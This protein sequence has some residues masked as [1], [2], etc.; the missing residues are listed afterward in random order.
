MTRII[1]AGRIVRIHCS[2][3]PMEKLNKVVHIHLKT[4]EVS[5]ASGTN[6]LEAPPVQ[7]PKPTVTSPVLQMHRK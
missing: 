2:R 4:T 6:R 1:K 7:K 5:E 3:P